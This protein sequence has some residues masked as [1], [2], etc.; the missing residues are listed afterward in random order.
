MCCE[1]I[2]DG[3]HKSERIDAAAESVLPAARIAENRQEP[4]PAGPGPTAI[5]LP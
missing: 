4:S 3:E 2:S 1:L 5:P